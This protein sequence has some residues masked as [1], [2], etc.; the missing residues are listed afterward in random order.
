M[1]NPFFNNSRDRSLVEFLQEL[2]VVLDET[3]G[4]YSIVDLNRFGDP[5]RVNNLDLL[6]DTLIKLVEAINVEVEHHG[7]PLSCR[8]WESRFAAFLNPR[9]GGSFMRD[10]RFMDAPVA[11]RLRKELQDVA[12]FD[13]RLCDERTDKDY[14]L[15]YLREMGV[16]WPFTVGFTGVGPGD[17]LLSRSSFYL[18]PQLTSNKLAYDADGLAF[19]VMAGMSLARTRLTQLQFV[20]P[21]NM[22]CPECNGYVDHENPT[23]YEKDALRSGN[24]QRD[25]VLTEAAHHFGYAGMCKRHAGMTGRL[26][27]SQPLLLP[28]EGRTFGVEI[29]C[30]APLSRQEKLW[31][32]ATEPGTTMNM[33]G[34]GSH[35]DGSLH[36]QNGV[37]LV[38]HPLS[39]DN[40]Q[41]WVR[42]L[43]DLVEPEVFRNCGLHVWVGVPDYTWHDLNMLLVACHKWEREVCSLVPPERQPRTHYLAS[44]A[45][46]SLP[47]QRMWK[48]KRHL[49]HYLY[50]ARTVEDREFRF[51][52]NHRRANDQGTRQFP[53]GTI[54]RYHWLNVHPFWSKKA[55][56]IRLHQGSANPDEIIEWLYLW[57][58][59]IENLGQFLEHGIDGLSARAKVFRDKRASAYRGYYNE[60]ELE[61]LTEEQRLTG[62]Y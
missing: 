13:I 40:I 57:K 3:K 45:P 52:V 5:P 9:L 23:L 30:I 27:Y 26:E 1:K 35:R 20:E 7:D 54:C 38:S 25:V 56:E 6:K 12:G 48:N 50:G 37:E 19:P 8:R 34:V 29:E 21:T 11:N 32:A 59:I 16:P 10:V 60:D 42:E 47:P 53:D 62:E 61:L 36:A 58:Q 15:P 43:C 51:L 33:L 4:Y 28:Q 41:T 31:H 2:A 49:L 24:N 17:R 18:L 55:V 14:T 46:M 44:G 39:W 22:G